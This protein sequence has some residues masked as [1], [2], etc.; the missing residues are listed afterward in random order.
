MR[1]SAIVILMAFMLCIPAWAASAEGSAVSVKDVRTEIGDAVVAY[2]QLEGM[3]DADM[4]SAINDDIVTN[5]DITSHIVTLVTLGDSVWG[6]EVDYEAHIIGDVFSTV[7]SAKGKQPDGRNGHSY[8]A[9]CYDL[10]TGKRL[11]PADIFTDQGKAAVFIEEVLEDSL[12]Q[13][14]SSYLE[15]YQLAPV[16]LDSFTLDADGVTFWY[17]NDQFAYLSEYSGACE[18]GYSELRELLIADPGGVPA[19]VGAFAE[20]LSPDEARKAIMTAVKEGKLPHIPVTLGEPM[21]EVIDRYRL[22]RTPDDFPGGRYYRLEAPK[23]RDI[24]I[25]SDSMRSSYEWDHSVVE[26]LRVERGEL[27][28][29]VIGSSMRDNWLSVLGEPQ[30][31]IVYSRSMAYDFALPPGQSDVYILDGGTLSLHADESGIL[32]SIRLQK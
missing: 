11:T 27:Y 28:G 16:P 30:E 6:L 26:G 21:S 2:P 3:S 8:T 31:V 9:L 24:Y 10:R 18:L 20:A 15:Y 32:R 4:Q 29:L 14:L 12:S 17:P 5:A 7:I 1:R 25:I 13:E 22:L 19:R 23:L